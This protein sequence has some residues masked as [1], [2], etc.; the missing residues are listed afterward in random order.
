MASL[1]HG[2]SNKITA[3]DSISFSVPWRWHWNFC[4]WIFREFRQRKWNIADDLRESRHTRKQ[5]FIRNSLSQNE[6]RVGINKI[7]YYLCVVDGIPANFVFRL[8]YSLSLCSLS[9]LLIFSLFLFP[10]LSPRH[11]TIEL[12][13]FHLLPLPV[14]LLVLLA[15]HFSFFFFMLTN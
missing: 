13:Y 12:H 2:I 7:H 9:V 1:S 15:S 8:L 3:I 11:S 4:E 6:K 10:P 14:L 5:S